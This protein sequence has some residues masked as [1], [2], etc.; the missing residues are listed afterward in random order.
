MLSGATYKELIMSKGLKQQFVA[1]EI[2]IHYVSLCNFLNGKSQMR[3][4]KIQ[5]LN[6]LLGIQE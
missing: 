6:Q 4:S 2:G 3:E 1:K 5:R